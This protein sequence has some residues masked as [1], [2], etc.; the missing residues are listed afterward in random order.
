MSSFIAVVLVLII[1]L[2]IILLGVRD[3]TLEQQI[4]SGSFGINTP[5]IIQAGGI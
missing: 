4:D 2:V 1:L 3:Y 5:G